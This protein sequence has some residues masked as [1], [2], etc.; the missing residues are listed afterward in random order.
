MVQKNIVRTS[1]KEL[2][3][4]LNMLYITPEVLLEDVPLRH[5]ERILKNIN[6]HGVIVELKAFDK[7]FV[8]KR[9]GV[10]NYN[11]YML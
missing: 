7:Y 4:K 1:N 9:K 6:K 10:P 3:K 2:C 8:L 5:V 11:V